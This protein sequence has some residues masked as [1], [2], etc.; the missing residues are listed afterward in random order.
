[1]RMLT[2][3]PLT[4]SSF[5]ASSSV[6]SHVQL[7]YLPESHSLRSLV[8]HTSVSA[9][10]SGVSMSAA[11]LSSGMPSASSVGT[12]PGW[13][14]IGMTPRAPYSTSTNSVKRRSASLLVLHVRSVHDRSTQLPE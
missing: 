8:I 1:M 5:F 14:A 2:I 9:A 3:P 7:T 4:I 12:D 11:C 10:S 13:N 6:M